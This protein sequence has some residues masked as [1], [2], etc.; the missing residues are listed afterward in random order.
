MAHEAEALLLR[1]GVRA[2]LIDADKGTAALVVYA[3]MKKLGATLSFG[4]FLV[5]RG[6]LS[7]LGLEGLERSMSA[8]SGAGPRTI[9][10]LGEFELL[11]ILGEGESGTVF[12]ARQASLE[13][14][15]AIKVLAPSLAKDP[16]ALER[17]LAEAR[18][19]AK[20]HHPNIVR[21]IRVAMSEGLYYLAME[22]VDGGSVR[23]LLK[24]N[25]DGLPEIQALMFG[26]QIASALAAA[27]AAG[28]VHRDVKPANILL[29]RSGTAKLADLGIA[30]RANLGGPLIT[31]DK[32]EFWGT[33]AYLAPEVIEGYG[34]NDPRSDLYSLGATLFEMVTGR[35]PFVADTPQEVLRLQVMGTPPDLRSL[36]PSVSPELANL[37]K[38]LLNKDPQQRFPNAQSLV[39][40][41][42]LIEGMRGTAA[43]SKPHPVVAQ[44]PPPRAVR[45]T[46]RY[47]RPRRHS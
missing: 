26:K 33:P 38:R 24:K 35:P 10:R 6:L 39:D 40:A 45:K 44:K 14:E 25:P 19:T 8:G 7:R 31:G 41:V 17:F 9:S 37:A 2:G 29:T 36:N 47:R 12:R 16:E 21:F 20:L 1:A 23:S 3:Q 27:H 43:S 4:E 32:S 5:D 22:L 18:V 42:E 34:A 30:V 13:R 28:L 11:E 15:V 46:K